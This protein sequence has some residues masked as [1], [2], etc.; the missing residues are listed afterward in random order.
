MQTLSLRKLGWLLILIKQTLRKRVLA[1]IKG[2]FALIRGSI[3]QD[4][5]ELFSEAR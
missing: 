3:H 2:H 1:D 4:Q 5:M